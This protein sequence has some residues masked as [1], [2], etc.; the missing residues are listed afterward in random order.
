M[1]FCKSLIDVTINHSYLSPLHSL[2][3][4]STYSLIFCNTCCRLNW[5]QMQFWQSLQ[6]T[7]NA[8]TRKVLFSASIYMT[9][10]FKKQN[11]FVPTTVQ[12][13]IYSSCSLHRTKTGKM[14]GF[15]PLPSEVQVL[16][17]SNKYQLPTHS[18]TWKAFW[19][20]VTN[21]NGCYVCWTVMAEY[22][23]YLSV[24]E[25]LK[26]TIIFIVT[27]ETAG[28]LSQVAQNWH[29]QLRKWVLSVDTHTVSTQLEHWGT[30]SV[31]VRPT[32]KMSP[33]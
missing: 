10:A 5:T 21:T 7:K 18:C 31:I 1:I 12:H 25:M 19:A 13:D 24:K 33:G 9:V 28:F 32:D 17:Q 16:F 11:C 4:E 8:W 29:L 15:S 14:W 20:A 26:I 3:L 22:P 2:Y 6:K 23:T 30:Q 27:S